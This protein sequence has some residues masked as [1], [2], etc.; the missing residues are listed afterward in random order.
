MVVKD[1]TMLDFF[2]MTTKLRIKLCEAVLHSH[3]PDF[4]ACAAG[5][6]H[7]Y[8]SN[9]GIDLSTLNKYLT[10]NDIQEATQESMEECESILAL[11]GIDVS[12]LQDVATGSQSSRPQLPSISSWFLNHEECTV[13][14]IEDGEDDKDGNELD[15]A[16]E[17]Q[18]CMDY[19]EDNNLDLTHLQEQRVTKLS[20]AVMAIT[21]DE[22]GR[23]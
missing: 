1:F 12:L 22:M 20:C 23:V 13:P 19:F 11:L 4:K 14:G 8:T 2:Y 10:D 21:S 3:T 5:Y 6:C 7:T 18:A 16:T 15:E 17:L 9:K